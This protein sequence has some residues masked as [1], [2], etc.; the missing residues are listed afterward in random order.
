MNRS[1]FIETPFVDSVLHPSDFTLASE[2]AFAHA[3][4]ISLIRKTKLTI[5][6]AGDSKDNWTSFPAVRTTLEKW[7]FLEKGS[8]KS[9]VFDELSLMVEK[10]SLQSKKPWKAVLDFLQ[11]H[12]RDLI[13]LATHGTEGP[14]RWIRPSMVEQIAQKSKTMTLFIPGTEG[15]FV[16]MNN[17]KIYLQRILVPIDHSPSPA[18]A[19]E[20]AV[21]AANLV[22]NSAEIILFYAGKPARMP[23]ISL[24]ENTTCS[25]RRISSEGD[26][27][28]QIIKVA[29]Q[30]SVD[31]IVMATAG[32]NGFLD[33]LR[34]SVTEQV[35]RRVPCPLLAVPV[36]QTY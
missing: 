9:A 17:G 4:A 25:W 28:N 24:P 10:I 7:G 22:E 29:Q 2:N 13:V 20:Y 15:G 33:V 3:L 36:K 18:P 19:M 14:P 32:H 31:L 8:S 12:P 35:L 23:M 30:H 6:H 27:V 26:P 1:T 11:E 21:K 16:S 5:L 34:G